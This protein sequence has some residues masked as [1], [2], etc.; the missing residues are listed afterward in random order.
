MRVI[1]LGFCGEFELRF[2][3]LFSDCWRYY[4]VMVRVCFFIWSEFF[5]MRITLGRI[6]DGVGKEDLEVSFI[7]E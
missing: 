6:N 4:F 2:F 3:F 5:F 1:I 7:L